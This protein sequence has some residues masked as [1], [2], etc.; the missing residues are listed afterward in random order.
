MTVSTPNAVQSDVP[1]LVLITGAAG[2]LGRAVM[3]TVQRAGAQ[4]AVVSRDSA[5]FSGLNDLPNAAIS[6]EADVSTP[7]GA[8]LVFVRLKEAGL[9]ADALVHCAGQ[10]FI[11]PLHRTSAEQYRACLAANLDSAFFTLQGFIDAARSAQKPGAVVM[12]STVAA[13]M[14]T[15]NHEAVAAAKGGIEALVRSAAATY[16]GSGIRINA[17]APGMMD[18]PGVAKFIS[19]PPMR[20]GAAKQY[21]L[22]GIG[23][24][25]ELA[26]LI[27][28]L[29]APQ[30]A[31]ITG[32]IWALDGGFSAIR[33][34]VK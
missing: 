26:E 7:E 22:G 31:R 14:G 30:A 2:G 8:A 21:P 32:Q 23:T 15:P 19:S 1:Q 16:A 9:H 27:A 28:Y 25:Q 34:L 18:T 13:R 10:A 20:E 24:A 6:I 33:P 4:V 29:I 3:Q 12:V 11:A 17:V 5:R